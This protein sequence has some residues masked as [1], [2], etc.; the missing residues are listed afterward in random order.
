MEARKTSATRCLSAFL[1]TNNAARSYEE[2]N[3]EIHAALEPLTTALTSDTDG[4]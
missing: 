2:G 4:L 3:P 1:Q